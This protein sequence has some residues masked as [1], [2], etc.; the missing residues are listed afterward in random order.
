MTENNKKPLT[1]SYAKYFA[2]GYISGMAGIIA[3][4]PF[5]TVKTCIQDKKLIPR[6]LSG[7]YRGILPPLFGVGLEKA[8]VFGTFQNTIDYTH[9]NAMSGALAGLTA[10]IVV[11][12]VERI[13][14]LLQTSSGSGSGIRFAE[15]TKI[16]S[17]FK[18]LGATWTREIP[19][20]AIYFSVFNKLKDETNKMTPYHSFGYGMCA[21]ATAWVFIYPQD[22]IKTYLQSKIDP[23]MKISYK[24]AIQDILRDGGITKLY[25][26]F[27]FALMRAV[28]LHATTFTVMEHL[29]SCKI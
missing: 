25:R 1:H 15:L 21:G 18:G 28:P 20:F 24:S 3:S 10:S 13:K 4:H 22:R 19:G 6:T 8:I 29:M 23:E 16:S 11:T 2:Y 9:S 5:D 26:G 7:L 12:P 27:S 17:L 14:I